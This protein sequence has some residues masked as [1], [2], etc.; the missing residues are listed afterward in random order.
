MLANYA[1]IVRRSAATSAAVAVLLVA[2][3]AAAAGVK[4]LLAALIAAVV[5]AAF[6]GIDLVAVGRAARISPAFMMAAAMFT[7]IVK[8]LALMVL[9]ARFQHTTV[10]DTWLAGLAVFVLVLAYTAGLVFWSTRTKMPCV[11]VDRTDRG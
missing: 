5:V 8:I 6:F 10:F 3:G 2:V 1:L 11:D 4:G 7:Y 9:V